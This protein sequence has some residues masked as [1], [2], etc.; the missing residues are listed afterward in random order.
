MLNL[1]TFADF[2]AGPGAD[3]IGMFGIPVDQCV[4]WDHLKET[5]VCANDD[6]ALTAKA[7]RLNGVLSS[8]QRIVLHAVLHA[9]DYDWLADE[10]AHGRSWDEFSSLGGQHLEAVLACIARRDGRTASATTLECGAEPRSD[11]SGMSDR[12]VDFTA[13]PDP[14][15]EDDYAMT[16]QDWQRFIDAPSALPNAR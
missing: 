6:G 7:R 12:I 9:C 15:S 2:K 5:F 8:R 11:Y 10:F 4:N 16:A 1:P 13:I 14:Q 3:I